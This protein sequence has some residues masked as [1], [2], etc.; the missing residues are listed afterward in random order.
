MVEALPT[1]TIQQMTTAEPSYYS[2]QAHQH[3]IMSRLLRKR[4]TTQIWPSSNVGPMGICHLWIPAGEHIADYLPHYNRTL[5]VHW[6]TECNIMIV[7]DSM[8]DISAQNC[9]L[10]FKVN[11]LPGCWYFFVHASHL[12]KQWFAKVFC[13]PKTY[14]ASIVLMIRSAG[15]IW[16]KPKTRRQFSSKGAS[17]LPWGYHIQINKNKYNLWIPVIQCK[18]ACYNSRLQIGMTKQKQIIQK[19]MRHG[20]FGD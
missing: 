8:P 6:K 11:M 16:G 13:M 4:D 20:Q 15:L 12:A 10:A 2:S 17:F 9:P 18:T 3:T 7:T 19:S 5:D 14:N 1:T